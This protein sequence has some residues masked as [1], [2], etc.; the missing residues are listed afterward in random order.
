VIPALRRPN[1]SLFSAPP[2]CSVAHAV[3]LMLGKRNKR[4]ATRGRGGYTK[5]TKYVTRYAPRATRH[6][7]LVVMSLAI[8]ATESYQF[9]TRK[10]PVLGQKVASSGTESCQFWTRKLP[11][12]HSFAMFLRTYVRTGGKKVRV[13]RP[14][15][16]CNP[17]TSRHIVREWKSVHPSSFILHPCCSPF[18]IRPA[19]SILRPFRFGGSGV[20]SSSDGSQA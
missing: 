9:R 10:L 13:T 5:L 20:W 14:P 2:V 6:S 17:L 7:P 11:V 12:F 4:N 8:H 1:S 19:Q 18:A 15:V 16:L 3:R